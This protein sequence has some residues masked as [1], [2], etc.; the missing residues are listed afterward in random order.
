M[1][2]EGEGEG[3]SEADLEAQ[4]KKHAELWSSRARAAARRRGR[5]CKTT[6]STEQSPRGSSRSST[7][8]GDAKHQHPHPKRTMQVPCMRQ[9][10]LNMK[11]CR[12]VMVRVMENPT[13]EST[14]T[15]RN[16]DVS[17]SQHPH[18]P[19]AVSYSKLSDFFAEGPFPSIGTLE[20]P[21][22]CWPSPSAVRQSYRISARTC[23]AVRRARA[24]GNRV[25]ANR[26]T[27]AAQ[28]TKRKGGEN[29]VLPSDWTFLAIAP[30]LFM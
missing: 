28:S 25:C 8:T 3:D 10:S 6:A 23:A 5:A 26:S 17:K 14:L 1:D 13:T 22:A 16:G 2:D 30:R 18:S 20:H 12:K 9:G 27:T 21:E 7:S 15:P 4:L 19:T 24:L 29:S 11:L